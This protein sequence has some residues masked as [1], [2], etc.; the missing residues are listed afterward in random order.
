MCEELFHPPHR[1]SGS[2]SPRGSPTHGRGH[3]LGRPSHY[4]TV[5]SPSHNPPPALLLPTKATLQ[6]TTPEEGCR[7]LLRKV[8]RPF[9]A[10]VC[11]LVC[12]AGSLSLS[13]SDGA[14]VVALCLVCFV[15]RVLHKSLLLVLL[16]HMLSLGFLVCYQPLSLFVNDYLILCRM[17]LY[18]GMSYLP[19]GFVSVLFVL[20]LLLV[21]RLCCT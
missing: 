3:T 1:S 21:R 11:M 5:P 12:S 6:P 19:F 7:P 8:C 10:F 4:L 16:K 13:L 20:L 9:R 18:F 2:G 14:C 17:L 15:I